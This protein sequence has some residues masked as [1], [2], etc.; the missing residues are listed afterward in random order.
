MFHEPVLCEQAVSFLVTSPCG[1]YVDGTVGGG[2]HAERICGLLREKGR[3]VCFDADEEALRVSQK[4]L[5]GKPQDPAFIHSNYRHLREGLKTL[6]IV[7]IDGVLLDLGVSSFQLDVG[8]RGFSF[9]SDDRLDMRLDQRQETDAW[10]VV[11]NYS[12][13]ALVRVLRDYGEE[14]YAR[15]ISARVVRA[16]PVGTTGALREAVA[17]AV[18]Q[19]FLT[20]SLARVFQALRIEVNGELNSL[21]QVLPEIV[22]LLVPG[23]RVV[24]ISYHSLEDRIVKDFFRKEAETRI[25]SG[26]KYIPDQVRTPTLKILTR[27]PIEALPEEVERNPRARSAKLRAA[28]R[29]PA[30]TERQD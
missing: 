13:D 20:K 22:N 19:R 17:S 16:R 27:K 25:P 9:R 29:L 4:K 15:L 23:G 5:E 11:N 12:E 14:R 8:S 2:G 24:V 26:H 6:G 7:R 30:E 1:I 10:S 21:A 18:G 3:L 28:E